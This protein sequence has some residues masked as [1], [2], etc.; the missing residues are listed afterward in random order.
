MFHLLQA[1]LGLQADA[2]NNCLFLDPCL[3]H[4]LPDITLR[5][6]EIGKACVDLRFWREGD[7]TRWDATVQTGSINIQEQPWQ[8]WDLEK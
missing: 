5:R 2:P 7:S 1:I 4:W 3:P 6:V 8:P